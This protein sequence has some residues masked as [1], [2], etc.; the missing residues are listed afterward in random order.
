MTGADQ[1]QR[2]IVRGSL[3]SAGGFFVRFFARIAFLIVA[4]RL[5]G[6]SLFGAYSIGTALVEIG[7]LAG[8]LGTRWMLFQWLD[9]HDGASERPAVHALFDAG[10]LVAAASAVVAGSAMTAVAVLP[11]GLL[12]PNT[13]AAIFWLAPMIVVQALIELLLAGTRWTQVMR[14]EVIGKSVVQPYVGVIAAIA[15]YALG[16]RNDGLVLSYVAGT[17]AAVA[18]A[19]FAV[20][21]SFGALALRRYRPDVAS[22]WTRRGAI[23]ANGASDIVEALYTRLDL[24]AVGILL[25][26][27][28]AGIYG[29]AKQ[30]SI[31]IRQIRQSFDGMLVPIAART[32]S[33]EGTREAARALA[34]VAR[35]ILMVQLPV[36][37][38]FGMA[39]RPLLGLFGAGFA[40]GYGVLCLLALAEMIQGVFGVLDILFVYRRPALG[41]LL[42]SGSALV[43]L[44]GIVLLAPR[45]GLIGVGAAVL[46]SYLV[47]AIGRRYAARALFAVP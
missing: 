21:R 20:R 47:R 32:L 36:V 39:G 17:L 6:A 11:V 33:A 38:L 16:A 12:A 26:E 31:V 24:Y 37:L 4:G 35:L 34:R 8:G 2:V 27:G 43:G 13:A 1:S 28:A 46:G 45:W 14:H 25:G 3:A 40:A 44:T 7:V 10:L 15:A 22:L 30:V 42:T 19:V 9:E 5:F 18:Y 41:M 29:M 23:L